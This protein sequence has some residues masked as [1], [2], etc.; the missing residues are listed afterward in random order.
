MQT[1]QLDSD[2]WQQRNREFLEQADGME[3]SLVELILTASEC[4]EDESEVGD[5][6][7]AMV[8]TGKVLLSERDTSCE[9]R[10]ATA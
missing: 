5:L 4:S 10:L 1:S 2:P 3:L 8:E 7:D 6:V 9:S